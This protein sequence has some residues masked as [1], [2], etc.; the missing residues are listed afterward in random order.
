[1]NPFRTHT[2]TPHRTETRVALLVAAAMLAGSLSACKTMENLSE[3]EKVLVAAGAGILAAI[4]GKAA[5]TEKSGS[6]GSA[7]GSSDAVDEEEGGWGFWSEGGGEFVSGKKLRAWMLG[8]KNLNEAVD[9]YEETGDFGILATV[10]PLTAIA[11]FGN[12]SEIKTLL[13][14]GANINAR[15]PDGLTPLMRASG[16]GGNAENIQPL[17]ANGADVNATGSWG[18]T[19]LSQAEK[20]GD[21]IRMLQAAGA[22][23]NPIAAGETDAFGNTALMLA[24]R[25]G[26]TKEMQ[27]LIA[28]GADVNAANHAGNTALIIAAN[29]Y[30]IGA[31]KLLL[32]KG[33]K[34]NAANGQGETALM[35]AAPR[36]NSDGESPCRAD[37]VKLLLAKGANVHARDKKGE[38]ALD[39][40]DD[41]NRRGC[42]DGNCYSNENII[43]AMKKAAK[44]SSGKKR[45]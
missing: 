30:D 39:W 25:R 35:H 32:E 27:R 29:T 16:W 9:L 7:G 33:A 34:V 20:E 12:A 41:G 5:Q 19:A 22:K 11:M 28:S 36:C 42:F 8:R 21:A 4:V 18:D 14:R 37:M 43:A 24:T 38:T 26:N 13:A 6:T 3:Q 44:K 23:E 15:D 10:T 17:L 2:P 45:K 1:M 31:V 40:A